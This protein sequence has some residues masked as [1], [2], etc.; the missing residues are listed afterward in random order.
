MVY[1][2]FGDAR[3][4]RSGSPCARSVHE[5]GW[6]NPLYHAKPDVMA[7]RLSYASDVWMAAQ[8]A[9]HLWTGTAPTSNPARL[10][11]T[12]DLPLMESLRLCFS[13]HAADRP[14]AHEL[15]VECRRAQK[16]LEVGGASPRSSNVNSSAHSSPASSP[17]MSPRVGRAV[18]RRGSLQYEV[19]VSQPVMDELEFDP[20]RRRRSL[21]AF[22]EEA[23][24]MAAHY[25]GN[26]GWHPVPPPQ[27]TMSG[28]LW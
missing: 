1:A 21:A 24:F 7:Q 23:D 5:Q 10:D 25:G 2:D 22:G 15:L 6:G 16:W 13:H 3:D 27:F 28:G 18:Y 11:A 19:P 8:T 12:P 4:T 14:S 9:V 20:V 26:V 17:E